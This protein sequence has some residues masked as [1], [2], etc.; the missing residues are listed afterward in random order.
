M[1]VLLLPDDGVMAML[2]HAPGLHGPFLCGSCFMQTQ[3][4]VMPVCIALSSVFDPAA[5]FLRVVS[6]CGCWVV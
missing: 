6:T 4:M 3:H 1:C 2:I 5:M